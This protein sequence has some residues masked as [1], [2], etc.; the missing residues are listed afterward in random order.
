MKT[1]RLRYWGMLVLLLGGGLS[2]FGQARIGDVRTEP[3]VV[4]STGGHSGEVRALAFTAA[5]D[6]L[7][8]AGE[9]KVVHVW[10]LRG[11]HA[12]YERTIRPPI[13][14][15]YLGAINALALAPRDIPGEP[16]Q[17]YLAVAGYGVFGRGMILVYRFPGRVNFPT[18]DLVTTLPAPTRRRRPWR[19]PGCCAMSLLSPSRPMA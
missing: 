4:L 11:G 18:G 5:G 9:D 16:G 8:S 10:D 3:L 14:R 1:M 2:A 6:R 13:W 15:G 7:L 19:T 12:A 17:R